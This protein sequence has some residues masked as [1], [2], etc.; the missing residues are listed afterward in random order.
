MGSGAGAPD[1]AIALNEHITA[2]LWPRKREGKAR[3]G[4]SADVIPRYGAVE[5]A[6]HD[7]LV[8]ARAARRIL[9]R[10]LRPLLLGAGLTDATASG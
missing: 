6:D 2:D 4:E 9:V 8:P 5:T 10:P 7:G 3:P 1:V